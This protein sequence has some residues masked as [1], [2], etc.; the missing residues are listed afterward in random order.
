MADAL[1]RH[2]ALALPGPP[3]RAPATE[4]DLKALDDEFLSRKSGS[5]TALMQTLKSLPPDER[6]A[7]GAARQRAQDGDRDRAR[8]AQAPRSKPA[9]RRPAASTSRCPDASMPRAASIR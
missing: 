7:F 1:H 8:R 2:A 5:V 4:R 3:R 6:R 9:A